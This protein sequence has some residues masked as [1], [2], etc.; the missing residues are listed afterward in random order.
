MGDFLI[1][2]ALLLYKNEGGVSYEM[3]DEV[4]LG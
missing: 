1:E 2:V 3:L 4:S